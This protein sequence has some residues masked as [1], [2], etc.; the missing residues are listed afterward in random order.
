[1]NAYNEPDALSLEELSL[2]AGLVDGTLSPEESASAKALIARSE[3]AYEVFVETV[4]TTQEVTSTPADG[5]PPKANVI[6][7]WRS[8]TWPFVLAAAASVS[9]IFWA[10]TSDGSNDPV[11]AGFVVPAALADR[12]LPPQWYEPN[13][14]A[15][16][17]GSSR[18]LLPTEVSFRLGS[19]WAAFR[20]AVDLGDEAAAGSLQA[21]VA[22]LL[23]G[24]AE[25]GPILLQLSSLPTSGPDA[26]DAAA[27]AE[28]LL[29]TYVS[30]MGDVALASFRAGWF[31]QTGL[32]LLAVD[33]PTAWRAIRWDELDRSLSVIG[34]EEDL[35]GR[36]ADAASGAASGTERWSAE[37]REAL[38]AV[39][40][41]LSG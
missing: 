37:A 14:P 24:R 18:E 7:L 15:T 13:W 22:E 26:P 4:A 28:P 12:G 1:M 39:V 19:R 11:A 5:A 16:R 2:I 9:A 27:D 38:L 8:R 21:D 3:A 36:L 23:D 33:D 34:E 35:V 10:A 25:V 20:V 30:Q 17:A 29:T 41:A 32:A 40:S 31:S 6:R